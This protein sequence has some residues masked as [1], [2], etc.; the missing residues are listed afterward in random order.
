MSSIMRIIRS[1]LL[2]F[3]AHESGVR[4]SSNFIVG[5]LLIP[6]K[7]KGLFIFGWLLMAMPLAAQHDHHMH[8]DSTSQMSDTV[9]HSQMSHAYSRNLPMSRNG[10][11]TG[12]LPDQSPVYGYMAA[13][14][15]WHLM[16][17][18]AAFPRLNFQN[19]NNENGKGSE[20]AFGMPNW[21]MMMAQKTI[22]KNGL[23]NFNLMVSVDRLTDGGNGYPLLFQTGEVWKGDELVDRQHPHDLISELSV[24]YTHM[25]SQSMDIT[26]YLGYPGEPALGPVAFMH[27]PS[28]MSNPNA[29][30]GHHWQDATHIVYGVSTLGIRYKNM[31]V[32][33]SVFTGREPDENRFVPD[34]P[35]FDSYSYRISVNPLSIVAM[36]FSQ[37]WLKEPEESHPGEDVLRTTASIL[38]NKHLGE[39]NYLNS[40]FIYGI[41]K[42]EHGDAQNSF[43]VEGNLIIK[44]FNP[45]LR[46]EFIQKT[47]GELDIPALNHHALNSINAITLGMAFQLFHVAN[48]DF[49]IG[50]QSTAHLIAPGLQKYYGATPL[51]AEIYLRIN[52]GLIT[53]QHEHTD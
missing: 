50:G 36:Q 17:H 6:K 46:Y 8:E 22:S 21:A 40:A 19:L 48:T 24:A 44:K 53:M 14:G 34:R 43:T 9:M 31:K 13:A 32:E 25:I 28:A 27:R 10:S 47:S 3:A 49:N 1:E 38:V 7:M 45:Y 11:G 16:F 29:T 37:G 4:L 41:N 33:G 20:T 23:L 30:L 39:E 26:L 42:P 2:P 15:K 18:G 5:V 52:P 35:K 51:S 12:W